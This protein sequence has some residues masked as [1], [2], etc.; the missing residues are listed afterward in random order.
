M[1]YQIPI[2]ECRPGDLILC[3]LGTICLKPSN[4]VGPVLSFLIGLF[5]REWHGLER[6][7]WH[8][9]IVVSGYGRT[10]VVLEALAPGVVEMPID[11]IPLNKQRAYRWLDAPVNAATL[12]EWIDCHL[13]K[14]YDVLAYGFTALQYLLRAIWNRYIPRLLDDRYTCW[15]LVMEFYEDS[16]KPMHSKRDCPLITDL[17]RA[18]GLIYGRYGKR[19]ALS[20]MEARNL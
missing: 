9:R 12:K 6:K 10:A 11:S 17:C 18:L 16:G 5:D 4:I 1:N 8:C 2:T 13:G 19:K 20:V 15:E 7:P 3:D 14:R